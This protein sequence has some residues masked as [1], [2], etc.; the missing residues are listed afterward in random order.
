LKLENGI[1][2]KYL[3]RPMGLVFYGKLRKVKGFSFDQR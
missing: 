2:S 1:I 3:T